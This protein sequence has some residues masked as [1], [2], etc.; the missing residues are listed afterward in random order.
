MSTASPP[1]A[2]EQHLRIPPENNAR[3]RSAYEMRPLHTAAERAE[4]G[5]LVEDSL[6]LVAHQRLPLLCE[7]DIPGLFRDEQSEPVGLFED[8]D[9][10]LGCLIPDQ[11]PNLA[12]W[13]IT[14]A[15]PSLFLH[16]VHTLPD[17]WDSIMRLITLW[18]SDY[19][20]RR[21]LSRIRAEAPAHRRDLDS[22]RD[23]GWETCGTGPGADGGPTIRL[24]LRPEPHPRLTPLIRCTVSPPNH[25]PPDR[26]RSAP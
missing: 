22:L 26:Y 2:H 23:M 7:G 18:A 25:A 13:G 20:A 14:G 21:E 4:A 19:A 8:D 5:A 6:G 17:R 11:K 3:I 9:V 12:H 10:L 1:H 16:H 15:G 24:E